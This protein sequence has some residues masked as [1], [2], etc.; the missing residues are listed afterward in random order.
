MNPDEK[1]AELERE[2][3]RLAE[4]L[5]G[6]TMPVGRKPRSNDDLSIFVDDDGVYHY[7]YYE[8]G[9][10]GFDRTGSRDDVLFWWCDGE[11]SRLATFADRMDRFLFQYQVLSH[12]NPEWGKRFVR[13]L[14]ADFRR[15]GKPE[16]IALLPDIGDAV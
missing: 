13:E 10:L 7:T 6:A 11:V 2:I 16:D 1:A 3:D 5:G 8:R 9:K 14:A 12:Y 4:A 15:W